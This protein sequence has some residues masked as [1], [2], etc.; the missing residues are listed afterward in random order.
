MARYRRGRSSCSIVLL[1]EA[2]PR[3]HARQ[4][5]LGKGPACRQRSPR[6]RRRVRARATRGWGHR[7]RI[8]ARARARLDVRRIGCR[9]PDLVPQT[10]AVRTAPRRGRCRTAKPPP[11]PQ[12]SDC[13]P[14]LRSL[15]RRRRSRCPGPWAGRARA[16][17]RC[18]CITSSVP[19]ATRMPG[20][21]S[22][23]LAPRVGAPLAGVGDDARAEHVGARTRRCA[24]CCCVSD[25]L[26]DRHLR[27]RAAGPP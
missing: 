12:I 16:R 15:E 27:A 10:A 4:L 25:E 11:G 5:S 19:P 3:G 22:S 18:C 6:R 8:R 2:R 26:G 14:T 24:T 21:P 7:H 13:V 1:V 17:R 9:A 20:M 23:E